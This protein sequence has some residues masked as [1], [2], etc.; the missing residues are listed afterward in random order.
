MSID[1]P[2]RRKWL[3]AVATFGYGVLV[4]TLLYLVGGAIADLLERRAAVA[5]SADILE[6]LQGRRARNAADAAG[7][8][9]AGSPFLEG[10]TVTVAGATL[11][12]RVATAVTR[13]GG[14]ILSSHVE[15][16]GPQSRAGF[17]A[18]TASCEI[19]QPALQ[20]LLYDLEAG[21]PYLFVDQLVAQAPVASVGSQQGR[22]RVMLT[23]HGQ[24]QGER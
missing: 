11:L 15:L 10:P 5:T 3:P 19:E 14:N 16:E 22:M 24:W 13:L 20:Q 23:V 18:V 6:Q 4:A 2:S 12:Q 9:P 17:V 7:G 8:L 21:M 1:H